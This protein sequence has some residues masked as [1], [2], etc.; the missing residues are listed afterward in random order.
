MY[1]DPKLNN[2]N[3]RQR[4]KK[5]LIRVTFPNGNMICYNNV[6]DTLIET[7]KA[8]GVE[9]F[10]L[11]KL[12]LC[13]LPLL[14]RT[15]YPKYKEWMKPICDGW[16]INAQSNS[17]AKFLQLKSINEQLNLG[18]KIEIGTDFETEKRTDKQPRQKAK[19]KL[20]IKMPDGEYIANNSALDS[21]LEAV[22]QIG[23]DAIK[24][25]NFQYNG[26]DLITSAKESYNQVQIDNSKWIRIPNSTK[27]KAKLL[28]VIAAVLRLNI[29]VTTI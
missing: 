14:S 11:I 7:L 18:L 19:D 5:S 3:I 15:I 1:N 24:K 9:T 29:E 2:Y 21:F 8:I 25:K 28:R 17:E 27:D 20:L 22:W 4:A 10:P 16:Y 13:H 26:A 12:E 23:I 6:T